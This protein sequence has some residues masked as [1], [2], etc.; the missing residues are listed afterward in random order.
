MTKKKEAA[1]CELKENCG[2]WKLNEE[3]KTNWIVQIL[4]RSCLL[5]H[6]IEEKIEG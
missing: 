6:E 4:R 2:F 1:T 5:K 3:G